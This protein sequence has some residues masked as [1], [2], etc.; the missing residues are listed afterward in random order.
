MFIIK[1]TFLSDAD[2]ATAHANTQSINTG[3]Y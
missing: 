3:V 2:G 1:R